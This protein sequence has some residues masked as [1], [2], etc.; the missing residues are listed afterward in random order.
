MST[1]L[2]VLTFLLLNVGLALHGAYLESKIDPRCGFSDNCDARAESPR[3]LFF[4]RK[5]KARI[6]VDA[7]KA[8]R[9]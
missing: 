4:A 8:E 3:A 1:I 6:P 9:L 7:G 5:W 2:S